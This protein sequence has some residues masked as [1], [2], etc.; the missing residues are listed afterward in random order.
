MTS[1]EDQGEQ[2]KKRTE[3]R[4]EIMRDQERELKESG[5][6]M[7]GKYS[8]GNNPYKGKEGQKIRVYGSGDRR[9][10]VSESL[11]GSENLVKVVL[12]QAELQRTELLSRVS[13]E[14]QKGEIVVDQSGFVSAGSAEGDTDLP[15]A[16]TPSGE[17]L[18]PNEDPWVD[19]GYESSKPTIH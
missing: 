9:Y 12:T 17:D 16:K 6:D 10:V 19:I 13:S 4:A 3:Y 1:P 7:F 15:R 2:L 5:A 11:I 14:E 18:Y 8:I